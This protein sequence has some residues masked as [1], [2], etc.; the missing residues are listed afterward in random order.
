MNIPKLIHITHTSFKD[1]HPLFKKN[2]EI[3][4]KNHPDWKV[5]FYSENDILKF[6]NKN[7][8]KKIFESY[9]RINTS[10]GPAKSD[11]FRYLLIYKIGGVYLDIK[12]TLIKNLNDIILPNDKYL[13]SYWGKSH[14]GWGKPPF[15][16]GKRAFQQWFIISE[17]NHPFL[18]LVISNVVDNIKNYKIETHGVGK[19]GVLNLTGPVVYTKSVLKL[20]D[21]HDYRL[22]DSENNGLK[23]SIFDGGDRLKHQIYFK[24]H[25]SKLT[26][27]IVLENKKLNLNNKNNLK[28]SKIIYKN[29]R[30]FENLN[31]VLTLG[32]EHTKTLIICSHERSGTHFLINSISLNTTYSNQ[33]IFDLDKFSRNGYLNIFD[34]KKLSNFFLSR[35]NFKYKDEKLFLKSLIKTHYDAD[36]LAPLFNIDDI[37]FIYIYRNPLDTLSSFWKF[38]QRFLLDKYAYKINFRE[39]L[40]LQ[41][42]GRSMTTHSKPAI[43]YFKRWEQHVEG[44]INASKTYD[45]INI[46]NY[47]NLNKNHSNEM[48]KLMQKINYNSKEKTLR[49]DYSNYILGGDVKISAKE[50]ISSKEFVLN[51]LNKNPKLKKLFDA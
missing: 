48:K 17:P 46:I 37:H 11:F 36:S 28:E 51:K 22:F 14:L 33:P 34:E 15:L 12:S 25:Y 6:I 2:I 35:L 1:V 40:N 47:Y 18:K 32:T 43:N 8:S 5:N 39:F 16:K 23:Y 50:L 45:N 30:V 24:N 19:N 7:Y 10:Y 38:N 29:F 26:S 31:L 49:P 13:L 42:S 4:K 21:F 9:T 44:W 41:P 3:I 27:P 20:I